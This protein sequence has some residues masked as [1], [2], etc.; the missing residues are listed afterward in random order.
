MD[1]LS[2]VARAAV[3]KESEI[4]RYSNRLI[5]LARKNPEG[6]DTYVPSGLREQIE[7]RLDQLDIP[8]YY[9]GDNCMSIALTYAALYNYELRRSL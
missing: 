1:W 3:G 2:I 9:V 8:C 7:K 5:G 6:I 4:E